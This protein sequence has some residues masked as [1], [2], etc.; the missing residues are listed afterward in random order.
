MA[1]SE[2]RRR[3]H[4]DR[5]LKLAVLGSAFQRVNA[6]SNT[7]YIIMLKRY[8]RFSQAYELYLRELWPQRRHLMISHFEC[9]PAHLCTTIHNHNVMH[10][11]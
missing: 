1:P 4:L 2:G 5:F 9:E 8:T 6:V 10:A 3:R 7:L 11:I